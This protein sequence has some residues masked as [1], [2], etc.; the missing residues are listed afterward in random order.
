MFELVGLIFNLLL[1]T[2]LSHM[3]HL[4]NCMFWR[5]LFT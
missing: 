1:K 4:Y 2:L 3:L 5:Q